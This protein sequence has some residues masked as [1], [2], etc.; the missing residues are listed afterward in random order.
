MIEEGAQV[1]ERQTILRLPDLAQMQVK[2][3]VHESKVE[4]LARDMRA[5]IRIQDAIT[6]ERWRRS[7]ISPSRPV[8]FRRPSRN[9]PTIVRIGEKAQGLRPGMTAE[10]E[11]LVAHL[12]DVL[13]LPVA[14]IVEQRG[15]S[16]AGSKRGNRSNAARS[17]SD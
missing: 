8:S 9:T 14:A 6:R 3:A 10:V 5:R 7:P 13:T 11:I 15:N 12:K 17:C 16:T 1:R 4:S 2:V